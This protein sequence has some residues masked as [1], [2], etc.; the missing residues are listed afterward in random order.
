MQEI[1]TARGYY[2]DKIDGK[3]GMENPSRARRLSE[4]QWA[5][6]RLLADRRAARA[7]GGGRS[8]TAW[9][10][11]SE[12]KRQKNEETIMETLPKF[13]IS[14]VARLYTLRPRWKH[15]RRV[16]ALGGRASSVSLCHARTPRPLAPRCC[17]DARGFSPHYL[18]IDPHS[19]ARR[20]QARQA[21]A[22]RCRV[23][24]GI[25][26]HVADQTNKLT[27]S[28]RASRQ[29]S[30]TAASL[31]RALCSPPGQPFA[32]RGA[33]PNSAAW[34]PSSRQTA[35]LCQWQWPCPIQEFAVNPDLAQ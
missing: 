33:T 6:G 12:F 18:S 27:A 19:Q 25:L 14:R 9:P 32:T 20:S 10:A 15:S 11:K 29:A 16:A 8:L 30:A 24:Q 17:N 3:A 2:H 31:K 35:N 21:D 23:G 22:R 5:H 7:Y 26:C 28:V 34:R 4:A 1:L 13:G